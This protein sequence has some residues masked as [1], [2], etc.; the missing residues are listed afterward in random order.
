MLGNRSVAGKAESYLAHP[1]SVEG[2]IALRNISSNALDPVLLSSPIAAFRHLS[3]SRG[4]E[5]LG[6]VR[7]V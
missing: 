7:M 6:M 4:Q 1:R 2:A 3:Y 5:S